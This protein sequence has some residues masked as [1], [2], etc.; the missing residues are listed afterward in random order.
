M[1]D[2]YMIMEQQTTITTTQNNLCSNCV[3]HGCTLLI[4]KSEIDVLDIYRGAKKRGLGVV[5]P[6]KFGGWG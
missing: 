3:A 6:L 5:T 1:H 4:S 2:R